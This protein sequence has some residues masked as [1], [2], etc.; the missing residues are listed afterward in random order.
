[1]GM[2]DKKNQQLSIR[3]FAGE[4]KRMLWI[5]PSILLVGILILAAVLEIWSLPGKPK[6][7][8]DENRAPLAGSISEK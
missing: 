4:A 3:S 1:M 6:P 2:T 5:I 8:L 7:I